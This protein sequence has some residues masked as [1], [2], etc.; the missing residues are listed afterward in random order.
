V[1]VDGYSGDAGDALMGKADPDWLTN[2]KT[3]STAGVLLVG[4]YAWG[5]GWWYGACS[6]SAINNNGIGIWMAVGATSD[7]QASRMLVKLN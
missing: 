4:T 2:G 7:V 3:F 1:T 5:N 6:T